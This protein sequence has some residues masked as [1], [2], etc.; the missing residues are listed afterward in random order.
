[1]SAAAPAPSD[2]GDPSGHRRRLRE[3]FLKGG[4]AG[5]HDYEVVELL[6]TLATPRKDCKPAAKAAMRH[7]KTLPAVLEASS[8]ELAAVPGIGRVNQIGIR[9]VKAVAERYLERQLVGKTSLQHSRAL[10]E[11]LDLRLAGSK[12]EHFLV[13]FLDAKNRVIDM[14]TLFSG[15]LTATSVYPREVIRAAINANAAA[16]IFVHNHPSGDVAPSPEDMAITRMLVAAAQVVGITVH[17]HMIIGGGRYY[18]FA[19]QGHIALMN[20]EL[21]RET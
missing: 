2:S 5:F 18:S 21:A 10:F 16:L 1:M 15:T 17:E 11:Y 4:L 3:R 14:E 6:L 20:R 12:R 19:D 13:V 7:F 9:L 8:R